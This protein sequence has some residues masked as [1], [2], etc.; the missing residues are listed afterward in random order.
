VATREVDE[1]G[2]EQTTR[3]V[4]ERGVEQRGGDKR[5]SLRWRQEMLVEV[6]TRDA[7]W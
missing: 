1:R 6:A 7:R 2:V 5:C 4:D 3:E